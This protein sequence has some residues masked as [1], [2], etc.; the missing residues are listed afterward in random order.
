VLDDEARVRGSLMS[1]KPQ[2]RHRKPSRTSAARG[3]LR[4]GLVLLVLVGVNLYVFLWRGG[5]SIPDV[6]EKAAVAGSKEGA[7]LT[8]GEPEEPE[9]GEKG[10]PPRPADEAEGSPD[11]TGRWVEGE[12]ASGDSL[13]KILRREG[14]TPTEKDELLR[15]IDKHPEV[16]TIREGQ[17]YRIRFDDAGRLMEFM[18]QVSKVRAVRAV[19][20]DDG[21][22]TGE[23]NSAA[24]RI[25]EVEIGGTIDS[26]LYASIK[27]SGEATQLVAFFVDVFAYDLN[28]YIDTH[29]GD[30][31]RMVVEK[32]FLDG[33]FLRYGHVLAA[34]YRGK[35]GTFRAFYWKPPK[36]KE[37]RY[38]DE[39]GQSIEKTFLKTPLKFS[40]V[41]SGFNPRRMHPVLHVRRGHFGV[42]YAAPTGTPIWAAASGL[43]TFRGR[44]GG[45]GNC[46]IIKHD[47]GY[48]TTYM[49]MSKFRKGQAVGKRVRQKDV[50]GYVGMT[51]LATGPHLHFSVRKGGR[52]VDPLKIKMSRGVGVA[53]A[54]RGEFDAHTGSLVARLAGISVERGPVAGG[55]PSGGAPSGGVGVG[56]APKN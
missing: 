54:D 22:L 21:K 19:R 45:A 42:D 43:V 3:T 56:S 11:E 35:A 33:H 32:E 2:R 47:N 8:A 20:A 23:A 36:D 6:M 55:A 34:E 13:D 46:V 17:T 12:V 9:E 18:F 10:E 37:G 30:S 44:K 31:Y 14:L 53:K 15:A 16:K 1:R 48:S 38:F 49:H 52:F 28:F 50:I 7:G 41:S 29:A 24:T 27:A 51:G 25:E 39:R 40:R 4:L 5:T 26:S